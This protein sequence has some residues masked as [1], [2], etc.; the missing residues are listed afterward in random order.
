MNRQQAKYHHECGCETRAIHRNSH[1]FWGIWR[2]SMF[3]GPLPSCAGETQP[4]QNPSNPSTWR[5]LEK[6]RTRQRREEQESRGRRGKFSWIWST[7]ERGSGVQAREKPRLRHI[8]SHFHSRTHSHEHTHTH[9]GHWSGVA[10][11]WACRACW[12]VYLR[13]LLLAHLCFYWVVLP[14]WAPSPQHHATMALCT[15]RLEKKIQ[16][17]DCETKGDSWV[18]G[19]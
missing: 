5:Q 18:Q 16:E 19:T 10:M 13:S 7:E 11:W 1:S 8:P 15:W 2:H 3:I 12:Q 17:K 14:P 9:T 4:P 6:G